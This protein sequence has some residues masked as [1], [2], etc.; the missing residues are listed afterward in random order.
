MPHFALIKPGGKYWKRQSLDQGR[1]GAV[2]PIEYIPVRVLDKN[3]LTKQVLAQLGDGM[4][5]QWYPDSLS[6]R[7]ITTAEKNMEEKI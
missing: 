7:W 1:K 3:E 5:A 2:K 6:C 4:P